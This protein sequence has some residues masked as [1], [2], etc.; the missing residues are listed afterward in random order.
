MIRP[1]FPLTML[2]TTDPPGL[3]LPMR[4]CPECARTLF[5]D[6]CCPCRRARA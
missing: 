6:G 1:F 2:F 4:V 5:G 3:W